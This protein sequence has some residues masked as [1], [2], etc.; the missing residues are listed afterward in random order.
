MG[1]IV[2]IQT[3]VLGDNLN[4]QFF[5]AVVTAFYLLTSNSFAAD[6]TSYVYSSVDYDYVRASGININGYDVGVGQPWSR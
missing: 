2:L 3:S 5:A 4:I 1:T 6:G